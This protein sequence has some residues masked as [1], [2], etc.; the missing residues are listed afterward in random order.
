MSIM[1]NKGRRLRPRWIIEFQ[2]ATGLQISNA[3]FL[4]C[5]E[6]IDLKNIFYETLIKCSQCQIIEW[7][8]E[9]FDQV[10]QFLLDLNMRIGTIDVCLFNDIDKFIGALYMR[11]SII[12]TNVQAVWDIVHEDLSL[13]TLTGKDGLCLEKNSYS[14]DFTYSREGFF[15]LT[16]WGLFSCDK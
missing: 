15:Q 12:L 5:A 6:T 14:T 16:T 3:D 7:P 10:T 11:S 1:K 9:S 8:H 2:L 13:M 4:E